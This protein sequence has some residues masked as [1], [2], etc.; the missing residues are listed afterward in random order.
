MPIALTAIALGRRSETQPCPD[1]PIK[2]FKC[3]YDAGFRFISPFASADW[4]NN[5]FE[6]LTEI[7]QK[8]TNCGP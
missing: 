1:A 7:G 3:K 8:V 6:V 5:C 2:C 4:H